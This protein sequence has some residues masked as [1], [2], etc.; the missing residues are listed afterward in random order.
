MNDIV[1]RTSRPANSLGRLILALATATLLVGPTMMNA[2]AAVDLVRFEA[3][4][5]DDG[6]VLVV[7]ETSSELDSIA[8]FVYRSD[9][10]SGPWTDYID[11][12]PAAGNEFIGATYSFVDT[13]VTQGATYYYYLEET[14]DNGNSTFHGPIPVTTPGD[15]SASPTSTRTGKPD[16]VSA[17]T[18]TRQY[19]NT[20][21]PAGSGNVSP[22]Q[23][24]LPTQ[25]VVPARSAPTRV[26][27]PLVTTPTP[28]GGIVPTAAA[29]S[30]T[31]TATA[32]PEAE[33]IPPT[34]TETPTAP[35]AQETPSPTAQQLAAV[36]KETSQPLLDSSATQLT[37]VAFTDA[38]QTSAA[39]SR[40]PLFVGGG[41]LL[42]AA[43]LGV[44]ALLIWR[45]R[46]G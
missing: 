35:V 5:Q 13:E 26:L 38:P 17:A 14:A 4:W 11:F 45:W 16:Q 2:G 37:P 30:P 32:T 10:P 15:A 40:L 19:T 36:P 22:T 42:A 6:S 25:T 31:Y 41:A 8:F 7:W 20:P 46:A 21:P 3:E 39:S 1:H 43:A 28:I 12:E 34:A 29:S 27:T 33:Q 24:S 18:A 9:S 44:I 23:P